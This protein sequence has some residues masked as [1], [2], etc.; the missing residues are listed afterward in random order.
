MH[1]SK[2]ASGDSQVLV[3]LKRTNQRADASLSK[4]GLYATSPSF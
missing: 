2:R 1:L 3:V 4:E